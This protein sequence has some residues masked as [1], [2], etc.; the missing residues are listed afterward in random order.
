M[1]SLIVGASKEI[2]YGCKLLKQEEIKSLAIDGNKK[3]DGFN[4]SED[5]LVADISN[6]D[7]CIQIAKE[8]TID[9]ILPAP[10]GRFITTWGAINDELNLKGISKEMARICTDKWEFHQK[11]TQNNLRNAQAILI[12][13]SKMKIP[14]LTPPMI[15]KPRFG[16]GSKNVILI[17]NED[18]LQH[19]IKDF[20]FQTDNFILETAIS[21]CEFGV[22]ALIIENEFK[23]VLIREKINTSPPSR[24]AIGYFS[25]Y[26]P[27][28][29]RDLHNRVERKIKTVVKCLG[30]NNC[31]MHVDVMVNAED[32]F[33]IELSP[34]PS[35][36]NLHN[37]FT[38]KA[39]G[40]DMLKEYIRFQKNKEYS[41]T[42]SNPKNMA[43][44]YFD[45]ENVKFLNVPTDDELMSL[46][47]IVEAR[48]NIKNGDI[49]KKINQGSDIIDDG[50]VIIEGTNREE[51]L[52]KYEEI[53]KK[54]KVEVLSK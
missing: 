18:Q 53:K 24:Q 41:L 15:L 1:K 47:N 13:N 38:I 36:H 10:I 32:E 20:N 23:M 42:I 54:F 34:R 6:E 43:L 17:K 3:A 45:Y 40:Y 12:D 16:S 49:R 21:G 30:L 44:L 27:N 14:K 52:A 4:F 2:E 25:Q 22:D 50:F 51:I 9:F 26:D 31:L 5:H 46:D 19:Q 7:K 33:I 28:Q 8:S 35:G 39:T 37:N 29:F 48:V 11:L